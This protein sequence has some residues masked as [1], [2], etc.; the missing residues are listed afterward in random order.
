MHKFKQNVIIGV[1]T[2]WT[3]KN[4]IVWVKTNYVGGRLFV[5]MGFILEIIN[6]FI[7][8]YFFN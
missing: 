7:K 5:I 4:E 2:K 1:R 3:L 6:A 8:H